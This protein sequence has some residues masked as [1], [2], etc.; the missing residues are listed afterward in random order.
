MAEVVGHAAAHLPEESLFAVAADRGYSSATRVCTGYTVD[1][2]LWSIFL[3]LDAAVFYKR[4]ENDGVGDGGRGDYLGRSP[5]GTV[6]LASVVFNDAR[7]AH[8]CYDDEGDGE[9]EQTDEGEFA[10][11]RDLRAENNGDGEDDEQ[12]V[13]N[14][15]GGA[16][17]E[18]LC[19]AESTCSARIWYDLPVLVMLRLD[20]DDILRQGHGLFSLTWSKG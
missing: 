17:G 16:H 10:L 5:Y 7:H 9:A 6:L 3:L 11:E 1:G 4:A 12:Y 14:H 15:V 18:E 8:G 2:A 20:Y 13:G 19:V